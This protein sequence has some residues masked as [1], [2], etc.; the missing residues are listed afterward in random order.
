[1][2]KILIP[3]MLMFMIILTAC[4]NYKSEL[5]FSTYE[6]PA[7]SI[8]E[9]FDELAEYKKMRYVGGYKFGVSGTT[10]YIW[11]LEFRNEFRDFLIQLVDEMELVES[12]KLYQFQFKIEED[13][14]IYY[15]DPFNYKSEVF[16]TLEKSRSSALLTTI[17][18]ISFRSKTSALID[19]F[20]IFIDALDNN[21]LLNNYDLIKLKIGTTGY[22]YSNKNLLEGTLYGFNN[23][24]EIESYI[25]GEYI[26]E[27]ATNL[28]E[29][30]DIDI[31]QPFSQFIHPGEIARFKFIPK[32]DG[33]YTIR[34]KTNSY[35]AMRL[36]LYNQNHKWALEDTSFNIENKDIYIL[37]YEL[38]KDK[39]YYIDINE[40]YA[41]DNIL[42]SGEIFLFD[43]KL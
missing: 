42:V 9:N 16:V 30:I 41:Y 31:E 11:N 4:T 24:E 7:T 27:E 32:E 19:G 21:K 25:N 8:N 37:S 22:L 43:K 34:V 38:E 13:F 29:A 33:F 3:I 39:I 28:S 36:S 14:V 6:I 2:K 23:L 35:R 18:P 10:I 5:E 17:L 20:K 26:F 15:G 1:M 40:I 12:N